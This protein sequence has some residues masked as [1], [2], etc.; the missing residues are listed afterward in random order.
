MVD[1]APVAKTIEEGWLDWD[2]VMA[3]AHQGMVL[4]LLYR[5]LVRKQLIDQVPTDVRQALKGFF[6]LNVILNGRLRTQARAVTAHLNQAGIAHVWLKGATHLLRA[7]WRQSPRTMMDLDVWIPDQ[8]QHDMA[9]KQLAK[10]G[11]K[12]VAEKNGQ[13]TSGNHQYPPLVHDSGSACL[14][15][16]ASLVRSRY[17]L[18]LPDKTALDRVQWH[19]WE[20]QRVGVLSPADQAMHA[21]I[22]CVHMSGYQ[23]V[24]GQVTLMKTHDFVERLMLAGPDA[25]NSEP[26]RR[27]RQKPWSEPA[28]M[29]FTYLRHAF[30][31]SSDFKT[32]SRYEDRLKNPALAS[33]SKTRGFYHRT[34]SCIR[35][36]RIGPLHQLP[37]RLWRNLHE[38]VTAKSL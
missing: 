10:L 22:Q 7:D 9:F 16:H 17:A 19:E 36:G 30:G 3:Q 32:S 8:D 20:G 26:F 11:Y 1:R 27:L 18:L 12:S 21:Y 24:S 14:E 37:A 2:V 31:V 13:V 35:E 4:P 23:F 5:A 29:F 38:I 15:L 25:L 34:V 28:N 6:D 33:L